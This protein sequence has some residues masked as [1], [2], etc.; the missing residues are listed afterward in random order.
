MMTNLPTF[1]ELRHHL[2]IPAVNTGRQIQLLGST[3]LITDD[4]EGLHAISDNQGRIK[5][6]SGTEF[7]MQMYRGQTRE[8]QPC[9]PTLARLDTAEKQFIALCRRVAFEDAIGAHPIVRFA[10]QAKFFNAPLFVDREGLAQHYGLATDMLDVTSN[11][12]VAGFFA[13][14]SWNPSKRSYEPV[15]NSREP[16]IIYRITPVLMLSIASQDE[17][18]GPVRIVGWQPLPRPEQQR[19]FVVKMKPGQD[20]STLPSVEVFQFQHDAA[21]SHRIWNAFDQGKALFPADAASEL[22]TQADSLAT[23]TRVQIKR[24]WQRLEN[25]IGHPLDTEVRRQV[26]ESSEITEIDAPCLTWA[27]LE[28]EAS[29]A[30]LVEHFNEIFSRIRYRLTAPL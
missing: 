20:F 23:F 3:G 16:G 5:L 27:G 29:H 8:Y 10:E 14:C 25:W 15:C 7:S 24:A 2:A 30:Q 4:V 18:L 17:P 6:L 22:A 26:E 1:D 13:T 11:F 19:A 28:V 9:T 21:I 12:D